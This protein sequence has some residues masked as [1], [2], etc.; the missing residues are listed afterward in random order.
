MD[1]EI[2]VGWPTGSGVGGGM[3]MA[4]VPALPPGTELHSVYVGELSPEVNDDLLR[5]AFSQ[6]GTVM[7][8]I[9]HN[10]NLSIDALVILIMSTIQF[11]SR[12]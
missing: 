1:R 4:P 8:A 11:P 5:M 9:L 3:Q 7:Y 10:R 6:C 2:K 12:P